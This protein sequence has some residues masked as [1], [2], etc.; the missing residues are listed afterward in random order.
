MTEMTTAD[1]WDVE[2]RA[3]PLSRVLDGVSL[4]EFRA[5][6]GAYNE[7]GSFHLDSS[8]AKTARFWLD[9][10]GGEI[11]TGP[12]GIWTN[13]TEVWSDSDMELRWRAHPETY[14]VAT[15]SSG[16]AR[17]GVDGE[18][19]GSEGLVLGPEQLLTD[20]AT[21]HT[22][23]RSVTIPIVKIIEATQV[24]I[25]DTPRSLPRF[26]PAISPADPTVAAWLNMAQDFVEAWRAGLPQHSP[27]ALGH[28]EQ[29]LVHILLD[30][31]PHS[32]S[33]LDAR[34]LTAPTSTSLRRA[35][36]FCEE[37]AHEPISVADMAA[38]AGLG[39][40]QLQR[41]FQA[42]LGVGPMAH[43]SRVR[44][45]HAHQDLR[46]VGQGRA[47]GTVTEIAYRW[48]FY[49]LSRFAER[50]RRTYGCTPSQTLR[51]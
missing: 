10:D 22:R 7:P 47:T 1:A 13:F 46:A 37:H 20:I 49:H 29:A 36:A 39:V 42:E 23:Q 8:D 45:D 21:P 15:N 27:L 18:D 51:G 50:Y 31:Q 17:L 44:L 32:M 40:R 12:S 43:L 48:G 30:I 19:L 9:R 41:G 6:L 35:L 11:P 14:I 26:E 3:I 5:D 24:R 33:A 38:A 2:H 25:G 4:E 34:H 16:A 28:F